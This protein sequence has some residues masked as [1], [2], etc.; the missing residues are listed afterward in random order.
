MTLG[1][2]SPVVGYAVG[3]TTAH[4]LTCGSIQ[5]PRSAV[6]PKALANPSNGVK[7]DVPVNAIMLLTI[8]AR[9]AEIAVS[10]RWPRGRAKYLARRRHPGDAEVY[11]GPAFDSISGSKSSS[12]GGPELTQQRCPHGGFRTVPKNWTQTANRRCAAAPGIC[13]NLM[14]NSDICSRK[15][16]IAKGTTFANPVPTSYLKTSTDVQ[17][18]A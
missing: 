2:S 11:H 9:W 5:G 18:N 3:G 15:R 4:R 16:D 13:R 17:R 14:R 8:R 6:L 1:I 10:R 7:I 12:L